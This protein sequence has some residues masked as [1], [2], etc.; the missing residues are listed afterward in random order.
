ML[1]IPKSS[2]TS[3]DFIAQTNIPSILAGNVINLLLYGVL[4]VQLYLYYIS[5]PR[6]PWLLKM[7]VYL[8]YV[9]ETVCTIL[10][11]YDLGNYTL[12]IESTWTISLIVIP[13]GGGI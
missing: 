12:S 13:A 1:V 8:I 10:L 6:D 9:I 7:V 11:T 3:L 2:A 4:T 5:F